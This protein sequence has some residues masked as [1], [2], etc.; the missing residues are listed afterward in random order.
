MERFQ[1][2]LNDITKQLHD[3]LPSLELTWFARDLVRARRE[4][5]GKDS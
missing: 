1:P 4:S 2:E 5:R 3:Y